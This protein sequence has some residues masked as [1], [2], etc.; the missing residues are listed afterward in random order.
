MKALS[1]SRH[2]LETGNVFSKT[3]SPSLDRLG[4]SDGDIATRAIDYI[5]Q[6]KHTLPPQNDKNLIAIAVDDMKVLTALM[7][8]VVVCGIYPYL[9]DRA[10][11]PLGPRV[12]NWQL[13]ATSLHPPPG[14]LKGLSHNVVDLFKGNDD[15]TSL[16]LISPFMVDVLALA[17]AISEDDF[18]TLVAALPTFNAYKFLIQLRSVPTVSPLVVKTLSELVI[19]R[20]DAVQTLLEFFIEDE[21]D[22]SNLKRA[23][24]AIVSVPKGVSSKNYI[25]RLGDQLFA[26]I[27]RDVFAQKSDDNLPTMSNS[28]LIEATLVVI[29]DLSSMQ[30]KLLGRLRDLVCAP[31]LSAHASPPLSKSANALLR[32]FTKGGSFAEH[33][34]SRLL[35]SIWLLVCASSTSIDLFLM[36]LITEALNLAP[37]KIT[38]LVK[39][40]VAQQ[41]P[42]NLE[43]SIVPD[44][45]PALVEAV[46]RPSAVSLVQQIDDRLMILTSVVSRVSD[47]ATTRILITLMRQWTSNDENQ[48]IIKLLT[49]KAIEKLSSD[50]VVKKKLFNNPVEI[51][52]FTFSIIDARAAP[53]SQKLTPDMQMESLDIG[54]SDDEDDQTEFVDRDNTSDDD[55]ILEICLNLLGSVL[56]EVTAEH[57]YE[58]SPQKKS[59]LKLLTTDTSLPKTIRARAD[60]CYE[61]LDGGARFKEDD[62]DINDDAKTRKAAYEALKEPLVP[63]RAYG[64]HL[65]SKLLERHAVTLSEAMKVYDESL[66]DD[67]SYIYLNGIKAIE[68]ASKVYPSAEVVDFLIPLLSNKSTEK[69]DAVLRAREALVRLLTPGSM[70]SVSSRLIELLIHDL[71]ATARNS[72]DIR[73]RISS[74]S[75]LGIVIS[76]FPLSFSNAQQEEAADCARGIIVHER[77]DAD[78]ALIRAAV[79]LAL[80]IINARNEGSFNN[81]SQ[82]TLNSLIT[83]SN[84]VAEETHD[85]A[86]KDLAQGVLESSK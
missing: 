76:Q 5:S 10:M 70:A 25:E 47:N 15:V 48:P 19:A 74:A 13:P 82:S 43:W 53:R 71:H 7:K 52:D 6:I 56:M 39:N 75:I 49:A 84:V 72:Q 85:E 68:A 77:A 16:L 23:V 69:L 27:S 12:P 32:L 50:E 3:Q 81:V 59:Q 9:G 64:I 26:I 58:V 86:L 24:L 2:W 38:L 21:V 34:L 65:I 63:S 4:A 46:S 78:V 57:E 35:V 41:L 18:V 55:T 80:E 62:V 11:L 51:V 33:L 45:D 67:D 42:P 8:L 83:V 37:Q 22:L 31:F 60:F 79:V 36:A 54:D 29:N 30:P 73:I 40:L 20:K 66:S 1:D 28:L 61:V 44:H 17:A 14:Y